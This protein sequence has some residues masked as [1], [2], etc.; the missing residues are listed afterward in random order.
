[1]V[2]YGYGIHIHMWGI[3]IWLNTDNFAFPIIMN[4]QSSPLYFHTVQLSSAQ[5]HLALFFFF[6]RK[7]FIL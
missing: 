2:R 7:T 1:M 6:T 5:N 3:A 4:L